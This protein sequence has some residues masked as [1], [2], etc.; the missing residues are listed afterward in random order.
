MGLWWGWS[1]VVGRLLGKDGPIAAATVCGGQ[2]WKSDECSA[3]VAA[4]KK[5]G[6][7]VYF[8][9]TRHWIRSDFHS[10]HHVETNG[11]HYRFVENKQ[12]SIGPERAL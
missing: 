2:S 12:L 9:P 1:V 5:T 11:P 8:A 6:P 7:V 10:G 3:F 4:A